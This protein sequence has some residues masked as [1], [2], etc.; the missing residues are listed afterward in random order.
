MGRVAGASLAAVGLLTPSPLRVERVLNPPLRGGRSQRDPGAGA[1]T[2]HE[3][4]LRGRVDLQ[5]THL[6]AA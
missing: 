5:L 2:A 3:R 4:A 6:I 1:T